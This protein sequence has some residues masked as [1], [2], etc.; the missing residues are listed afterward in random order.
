MAQQQKILLYVFPVIFAVSGINFPIG[1]LI[2]WLTTNLWT[3]GQQFYV[4][5]RNPDPGH[6]GVRRPAEAAQ[7]G[8]GATQGGA[9]RDPRHRHRVAPPEAAP[10]AE[11]AVREQRKAGPPAAARPAGQTRR[12]RTAAAGAG[13]GRARRRPDATRQRLRGGTPSSRT[14]PT[15]PPTTPK[16]SERRRR[17]TS[18]RSTRRARTPTS[19]RVDGAD[20]PRDAADGTATPADDAR[21]RGA[22][23]PPRDGAATVAGRGSSRRATSRRTTSRG[24]STSPTSTATSTWTSRATA[25]CLA[26]SARDLDHLVGRRRRGARRPAGAHPA[27]GAP[28][29]RRAAAG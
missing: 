3:M 12:T 26:S 6:A 23:T 4:I 1:V 7:G 24:C 29:D 5:R 15:P 2:Y 18:A 10:A 27:G 9:R 28:R 19:R 8:Q 16:P 17:P 21:R 20:R 14:A 25:R 13:D 11:A 22:T